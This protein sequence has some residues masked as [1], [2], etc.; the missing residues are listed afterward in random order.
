MKNIHII[1]GFVFVTMIKTDLPDV[2]T[3]IPKVHL[4]SGTDH[5]TIESENVDLSAEH[6]ATIFEEL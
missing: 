2:N 4:I 3:P 5:T 1:L 6:A